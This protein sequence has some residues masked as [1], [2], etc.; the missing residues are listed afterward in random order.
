MWNI[1]VYYIIGYA[2]SIGLGSLMTSAFAQHTG[3]SID[4][5]DTSEKARY[6][7]AA[8]LLGAIE[9]L[10]YTTAIIMGEN[11]FIAL[12]LTLKTISQWEKWKGADEKSRANFN[13]F[14]SGTG[15][16]LAYGILGGMVVK[17]LGSNNFLLIFSSTIG[18]VILTEIFIIYAK[19]H[20]PECEKIKKERPVQKRKVP[21]KRRTKKD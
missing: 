3:R 21:N 17:W 7:W 18:L 16:S 13:N 12:W 11:N 8:K 10:L 19:H 6:R 2:Y 1:T 20:K 14:L 5:Y 9:R 4:E 15:L